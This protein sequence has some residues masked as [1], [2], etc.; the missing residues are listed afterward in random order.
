MYPNGFFIPNYTT[1]F[2]PITATPRMGL[3]GRIGNTIKSVNWSGLLN[4]ADRTL[5]L[6][7]QTIPLVREAKPMFS[8]MKSMVKL[9]KAF[10]NETTP[11]RNN[12]Q[13][14][15]VLNTSQVQEANN[16]PARFF[17]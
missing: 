1:P 17:I 10:R 16:N 9:A 11:T 3:L 5:G 8:N 6:V 14:N 15:N 7:N 13:R 4:G 2:M 12:I